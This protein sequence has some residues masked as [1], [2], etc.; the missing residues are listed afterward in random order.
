[1]FA[2]ATAVFA[3]AGIAQAQQPT[4]VDRPVGSGSAALTQMMGQY[5]Q[6]QTPAP[7]A[8]GAVDP[9][10]APGCSACAPADN[11]Y[12]I[13]GWLAADY[14]L[15]FPESQRL[16]PGLVTTG[17]VTNVGGSVGLPIA[18]GL[19]IDTGMWWD[20]EQI[21][22]TQTI[23]DTVFRSTNTIAFGAGSTI[24]TNAGAN[25]FTVTAPSTF[26]TW[27]QYGDT[28]AN[29][30][31]R[32]YCDDGT[33]IYFL[34]GTKL[35]YLEEDAM[36]R[37]TLAGGAAGA[38]GAAN[39]L[40][41]FH[42]RNGFLG[43]DAGF[44]VKS[45]FGNWT[46]DAAAKCALG[47]NYVASTALGSNNAA[48]AV[49]GTGGAAVGGNTQIFTNDSNI[50][51]RETSYFSVIPELNLNLAYQVTERIQVRMGYT[52]MAWIN[53]QRPGDQID[54]TLTPA[55]AIAGTHTAPVVPNV[56]STYIIHGLNFGATW[57]Y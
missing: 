32:L 45:V 8:P 9:N 26:Q 5:N 31:R 10:G 25:S 27:S 42:V 50:G 23:V 55:G 44:L 47:V 2:I 18:S 17:G 53:T 40:D 43:G 49:A 54:P 7:A 48:G 35:A 4:G 30:M 13:H 41:E 15:F 34:Y 36:F 46:V 19:R 52:F 51:Y 3:G 57:K 11:C 39:F 24:N 21:K 56:T 37:Y 20:L 16:Q 33:R 1:M 28:E 12:K 6:A 38:V 22:G 14:L 29:M